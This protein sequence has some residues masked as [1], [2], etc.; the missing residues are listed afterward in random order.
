MPRSTWIALPLL[1]SIALAGCAPVPPP[2]PAPPPAAPETSPPPSPAA[3]PTAS[4]DQDFVNLATNMG[5]S[6]M[7]MGRLADGKAASKEL[8]RLAAHMIA[9]HKRA[10]ERLAGLAKR[11]KLDVAPPPDE[12]PPELLTSSGPDFDKLYIGLVVKG[13]QDMIALFE[14]EAGG[15]QDPRLKHFAREMLPTL[16]HHLHEAQ[17]IGQKLGMTS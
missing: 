12:P 5:A 4:S 9:D 11:L 7:G 16:R 10:N 13:H 3:P 15:G 2:H 17:T 6:E 14:S 1:V 8:R